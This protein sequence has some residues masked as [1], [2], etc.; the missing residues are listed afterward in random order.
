M[1]RT[2]SIRPTGR[3]RACLAFL[4]VLGALCGPVWTSRSAQAQTTPAPAAAE[5]ALAA[6]I[7]VGSS[8]LDPEE[9][10]AAIAR[11]LEVDVRLSNS[12]TQS[13]LWVRLGNG[14][15]ATVRFQPAGGRPLERTV[16]LPAEPEPAYETVALLAGNL[17]RDEASELLAQ[18]RR[19]AAPEAEAAPEGAGAAETPKPAPTVTVTVPVPKPK[20][21]TARPAAK[22]SS[23][24]ADPKD[25]P[26]LASTPVNLSVFYPLAL[27]RDSDRRRVVFELGFAYSRVG[28][29][30][31]LGM[32]L[33]PLRLH[34][35]LEGAAFSLFLNRVEGATSGAQF[36]VGGNLSG[37]ALR[38]SEFAVG[39]NDRSS[40]V[41]GSQAAVGYNHAPAVKGVQLGVGANHTRELDG[42][43][44]AFVNSTGAADGVQGGL[45]NVAGELSGAQLGLVNVGTHVRGVQLG[46]VNIADKV[47]GASVGILNVVG[48]ARTRLVGWVDSSAR[49][50]IGIKYQHAFLFTLLSGSYR[51]NRLTE[52]EGKFLEPA[53]ALGGHLDFA[54]AF[55]ELD[56]QYAFRQASDEDALEKHISRYRV[57]VG[58]DP[59]RSFGAFLGGAVEQRFDRDGGSTGVL[60]FAGIQLF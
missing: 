7:D 9:V 34:R 43:Q 50:N 40:V 18:L 24:A 47:D 16:E 52:P 32:T 41:N 29:I 22:P 8:G 31:G 20:Q 15:R 36:S 2:P 30:N 12:T 60:G 6:E 1:H 17:A 11:E 25:E 28:A 48:N 44:L 21:K 59:V 55:V 14:R 4:A 54:P 38:G 5:G 51:L 26:P 45:V 53:F 13:N 49:G 37:G 10:R 58:Y 35:E 27:Y 33:G 46:L 3:P 23:R 42:A 19:N 56:V 57:T 39:F